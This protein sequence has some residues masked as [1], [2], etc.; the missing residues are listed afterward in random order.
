MRMMT[1]GRRG[2][3]LLLTI[4]LLMVVVTLGAGL[5]SLTTSGLMRSR[6]DMLRAQS[7]DATEAGVEAAISQWRKDGVLPLNGDTASLSATSGYTHR[8]PADGTGGAKVIDCTGWATLG[9]R[10]L[11]RRL[12]VPVTR[13]QE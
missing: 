10:T 1:R 2:S 7:L 5:V 13:V 11:R 8:L 3:A 4:F 6:D 9:P 12:Q